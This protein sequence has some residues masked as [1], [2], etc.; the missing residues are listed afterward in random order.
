MYFNLLSSFILQSQ[1]VQAGSDGVVLVV[2][3]HGDARID[4]SK[5]GLQWVRRA[6]FGALQLTASA[7]LIPHISK[8]SKTLQMFGGLVRCCVEADVCKYIRVLQHFSKS[9][10]SSS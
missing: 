9:T 2:D 5:A 6:D 3:K 10:G 4:F 1:R 8:I 7:G